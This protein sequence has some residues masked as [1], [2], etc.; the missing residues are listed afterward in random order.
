MVST[1]SGTTTFNMNVNEI[2]QEAI[3]RL[4]GE[5]TVGYEP[6]SARRS[7]NLL[8]LDLNNRG[9]NLWA[10]NEQSFP[11]IQGVSTYLLPDGTNG[12]IATVD[13]LQAVITNADTV[14]P[15]VE[16]PLVRISRETYFNYPDKVQQGRPV[17]WWTDRQLNQVSMILWLTPDE[18]P[19]TVKYWRKVQLMDVTQSADQII[20][21]P[22]RF[23]PAVVSGLAHY[24][25]MKR[26]EITPQYR[27]TL[28]AQYME[29]LTF[30]QFEDSDRASTK[31]FIKGG[32]GPESMS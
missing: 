30:A 5:K 23:L 13:A 27:A 21:T 28:K 2:I 29:D 26:P 19:R 20:D 7:L 14:N 18:T 1:V 17:N 31:L 10:L 25:A 16:I 9:M 6:A 15:N 32:G 4:G 22:T 24:M 11:V 12:T 8:L 3:D